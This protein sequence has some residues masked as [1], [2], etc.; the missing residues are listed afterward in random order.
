MPTNR[1]QSASTPA[2]LTNSLATY[3][4]VPGSTVGKDITLDFCNT[5]TSNAIGIT[6]HLVPS[7]GSAAAG[8]QI[9][10]ETSPGGMVLA[11]N[12]WRSIPLDQAIGAG[13]FIQIKASITAKVTVH[14]TVTEV[15]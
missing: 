15:S 3:Y 10:S 8:N 5:D 13:A 1:K 12:E 11:A 9:F 2:V 14:L 6:M 7:G 4:T